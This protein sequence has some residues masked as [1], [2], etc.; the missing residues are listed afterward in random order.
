MIEINN[1][2]WIRFNQKNLIKVNPKMIKEGK[3]DE[4]KV[5]V[6]PKS[7]YRSPKF[8]EELYQDSMALVRKFGKPD[9]FITITTN[10]KWQEILDNIYPGQKPHDRPDIVARVFNAK[11][12]Q[13]IDEITK[14][15]IFG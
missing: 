12:D 2:N 1:L 15:S 9:L 3:T 10:P 8:Y 5:V 7:Y 14:D 4:G 11:L 13:L 6:L